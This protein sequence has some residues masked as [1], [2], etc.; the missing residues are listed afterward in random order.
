MGGGSGPRKAVPAMQA[1]VQGAPL[2]N[3]L[4]L[5]DIVG[6]A[7]NRAVGCGV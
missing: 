6:A 5:N 2:L 3:F 4:P 7:V 1:V